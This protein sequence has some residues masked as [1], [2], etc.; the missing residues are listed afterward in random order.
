MP[1]RESTSVV[2]AKFQNFVTMSAAPALIAVIVFALYLV[3][4]DNLQTSDPIWA[5][6]LL[7]S[8][9]YD[10]DPFLDEYR[11]W[12]EQSDYYAVIK[13]GERLDTLFPLGGPLLSIAPTLVLDAVLPQLRGTTL[14]EFLLATPPGDPAVQRIQLINASLIVALSAAVIYL[15]SREYLPPTYA[16]IAVAVYAF[17][18]SAYSTASRAMWQHG[19][20]MLMVSITLLLLIKARHRP[21]LI[22]YAALPL[23]AAYIVRPTNVISVVVVSIYVLFCYRRQFVPFAL[24][25]L[26][27]AAPFVL[28]NLLLY[29]N[30][31][32]PYYLA[33]RLK[34]SPTMFEALLGNLVSP[35]RGI[36]IFS[37]VFL[38]IPVGA[39]LRAW[40]KRWTLLDWTIL[41]ILALHWLVISSF[42][43]WWAGHSFGP[44]FF[45]DV[46]PYAVYFLIAILEEISSAQSTAR[47]R[48]GLGIGFGLLALASIAIHYRGVVSPATLGW[49]NV[50]L[51]VDENPERLWDWTDIQFLRGL[52]DRLVAVSP[53]RIEASSNGTPEEQ[54]K[55][56]DV[57]LM[58]DRPVDITLRLPGRVSLA[59]HTAQLFNL[60]PLP[61]GGMIGKLS[62]PLSRA[63]QRRFFIEVDSSN[64]A[65][66]TSLGAIE[67]VATQRDHDN[68][69]QEIQVIDLSTATEQ[70]GAP[71]RPSDIAIH[72][73]AGGGDLYALFGAGWYDEEII[74]DASWRWAS[75]PAYLHIW[76]D[77]EQS[78]V[79]ELVPSSIY[80]PAAADGLGQAGSLRVKTWTEDI[81]VAL[82]SGQPAA[83]ETLLQRGWNTL[84]LELEAG[85][86]RP[87]ELIPDHFDARALSFS[88]DGLTILGR[89]APFAQP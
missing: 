80:D 30:W 59:E 68:T 25:G 39:G 47:L 15:I 66:G 32:S 81:A 18:T 3:K 87:A 9:I 54:E 24:L 1:V 67:V 17:G 60:D 76:S 57:G 61:G 51:N 88:V 42:P 2:G 29:D 20:S 21:A 52:D 35:A 83:F 58:A 48:G 86:F 33:S 84:V 16:L 23:A 73:G 75:R 71:S 14:Q 63:A 41:A 50:P 8:L 22:P 19:P 69:R 49:N 43:H 7:A 44:R 79:V 72:C 13:V 77:S 64:M 10:G 85:F 56:F 38:M 78:A 11:E 65:A 5:P 31:L 34:F 74:G 26:L 12:I 27:A 6:H 62:E 37:P 82:H 89:C 40:R 36:L 55:S 46:L 45:S 4:S 28:S 53:A 70:A